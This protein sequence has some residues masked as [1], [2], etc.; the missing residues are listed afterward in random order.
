MAKNDLSNDVQSGLDDRKHF[1]QATTICRLVGKE[2]TP[3][4]IFENSKNR[5]A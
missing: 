1:E 2:S 4:I 3:Q 5:T